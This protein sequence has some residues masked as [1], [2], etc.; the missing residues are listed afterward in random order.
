MRA[1]ACAYVSLSVRVACV[2]VTSDACLRRASLSSQSCPRERVGVSRD[3]CGVVPSPLIYSVCALLLVV[4][5]G[6]V[7]TAIKKNKVLVGSADS[8]TGN[9]PL[10]V[11]KR[12]HHCTFLARAPT[13][14]HTHTLSY[15]TP[16]TDTLHLY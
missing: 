2:F 1:W 3:P 16:C 9:Q 12:T 15:S 5:I 7:E 4:Q 8:K 10:H 6:E 11:G 14:P 13:H